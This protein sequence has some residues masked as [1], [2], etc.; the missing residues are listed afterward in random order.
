MIALFEFLFV[1]AGPLQKTFDRYQD[2]CFPECLSSLL[3]RW[4]VST[5]ST[6]IVASMPSFFGA[7]SL[8]LVGDLQDL[9]VTSSWL[10]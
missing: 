3:A 9:I 2:R 7:S 10:I 5:T 1:A 4:A 8:S 6:W